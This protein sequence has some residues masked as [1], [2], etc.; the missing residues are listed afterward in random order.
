MS[1]ETDVGKKETV[2]L[3]VRGLERLRWLFAI[4]LIAGGSL[5][6][7]SAGQRFTINRVQHEMGLS[8]STIYTIVQGP[9]GFLWFG[10]Q[11]GL[12]KYDGHKTT[13]YQHRP[14]DD[15]SLLSN[16]ISSMVFDAQGV[17]WLG[18]WGGGLNRFDPV[19]ETFTHFVNDTR[20]PR[21]LS[22]NLVQT[23]F[24]DRRNRIWV[25]TN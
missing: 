15:N 23:V 14:G 25:G 4:L 6:A 9:K 11:N 13:I 12:N 2:S 19:S 10:T 21:S 7:A 18:T 24:R 8:H 1:V 17:L 5:Y 3:V 22:S 16:S 20:D